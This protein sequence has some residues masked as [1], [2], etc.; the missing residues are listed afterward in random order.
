V[1]G[2]VAGEI[3]MSSE[4]ALVSANG[5]SLQVYTN[6][7]FSELS[8]IGSL[9]RFTADSRSKTVYVWDFNSGHH[10]DVSIGLKLD[11]P[12]NSFDFFK[13]HAERNA[14]GS[15]E[16]VGSDFLQSFFGKLTERDKSF[17]YNLL[18]QKWDWVTNY[19]EVTR[20]I[21]SFRGVL[22]L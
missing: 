19:I 17:L 5:K 21:D 15:Y 8:E 10:A 20:W 1:F 13:G 22:K 16:M 11:D 14:V 4:P 12:F 9:V 6:P 18:K 7:S 2:L 3:Q